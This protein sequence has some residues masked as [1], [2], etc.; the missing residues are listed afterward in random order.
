ME[1]IN[2][3]TP[4][5]RMVA[6]RLTSN[7]FTLVDI[8]CSGGIDHA[9]RVF[10]NRLKA[11]A[12]DPN[13]SEVERLT[14][15]ETLPGVQY[16]AAFIGL[17][18]DDPGSSRLRDGQFWS[19]SPWSRLSVVRTMQ[20]SSRRTATMS[21]DEKLKNNLWSAMPLADR[22]VILPVFLKEHQV[23][24]VDFIKVDVDGADFLILRSLVP[25]LAENWVL[26][27]GIEVNFFGTDD[28]E[29]NTLHNVDRLM[30][31]AG[32]ELFS[33]SSRPYSMAALPAPYGGSAPGHTRWG[34]ILQGDALYLR[35]AAAP[36]HET[37]ARGAGPTKLLKL[38]AIFSIA[39]LPDCAA[40]IL[41]HYRDALQLFLDVQAGLDTLTGQCLR[42]DEARLSYAEYS[43][44]FDADDRRFYNTEHLAPHASTG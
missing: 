42:D 26:G 18:S 14:Q 41:L 38:A 16:T 7:Y 20:L 19:R 1:G 2:K 36:E 24:D 39:N 44:Q 31:K 25:V 23:G 29:V 3:A 37:W 21:N 43:A 5:A 11:F 9:W 22:T 33:L 17:A 35:D 12:F 34:R 30:K 10:G 8:G 32:F 27:V 4:F 40:E 15:R 13:L 28:P 6:E